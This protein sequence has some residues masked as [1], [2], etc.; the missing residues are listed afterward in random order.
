MRAFLSYAGEHRATADSIALRLRQA[1]HDVFF[2][3]D[4]LP[5]AAS[6]DD[7]IR[8]GVRRSDGLVFLVSP[9]AVAPGAYTLTEMQFARERW[10]NPNGR[11]LPVMVVPTPYSDI[12]EY[13]KAVTVL[14]P[15]GNVVA[16]TVAAVD[17]LARAPRR[18]R[19]VFAAVTLA[20]AVAGG[21]AWRAWTPRP[22]PLRAAKGVVSDLATGGAV[23]GA[24]ME[25]RC[26]VTTLGQGVT[27]DAGKFDLV[28]AGCREEP[29]LSVRHESYTEHSRRV[30]AAG[31]D[32]EIGLLPKALGG[33][34]LKEAQGIVVGHFRAPVSAAG[35]DSDL[36][37]RIA[38]ALTYDV[39]TIVQTLNLPPA[40]Q[41]RF[42]ACDEAKPRSV[43]FAAGYA[44]ALK[45]DALIVGNIEPVNGA[46]DV[47]AYIGDA[48][49]LFKPPVPSMARGVALNDPAVAKLG[50]EMHAAILTAVARGYAERRRFTE[51]VDVAVAAGR[52]LSRS[53]SALDQTLA[54]CQDGTGLADL[55]RGG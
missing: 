20:L 34:V 50:P 48:F 55:R 35:T 53:T 22:G 6:F 14:E 17:R 31:D 37:G 24:T 52:L 4:D 26:G 18:R 12:P 11:V 42:L 28:A 7:R 39:L 2:D 21:L 10:P 40:L 8:E 47:R 33:C 46:F 51:C 27:D 49:Q 41:P 25:M 43:D 36:A 1:G 45:A 3:K 15:R 5:A 38:E 54:R 30:P 32:M 19:L 9:E 29:T 16:E 44:R 13:L 23:A